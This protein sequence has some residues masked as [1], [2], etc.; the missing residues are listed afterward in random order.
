MATSKESTRQRRERL[1]KAALNRP[2]LDTKGT[3][4]VPEPLLEWLRER[5]H[6][7][8]GP[9]DEDTRFYHSRLGARAVVDLLESISQQE[10]EEED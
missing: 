6:D 5:F 1:L 3:P 9:V 7:V 4:F 8:A 2:E 10:D